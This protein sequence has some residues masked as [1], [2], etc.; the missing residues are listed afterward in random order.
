MCFKLVSQG[1]AKR[2]PLNMER[3]AIIYNL[4]LAKRSVDGVVT[5]SIASTNFIA[6]VSSV[7][8]LA[9]KVPTSC[10]ISPIC[11]ANSDIVLTICC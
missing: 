1:P 2:I 7:S 4:G 3:A 10:R 11:F 8:S 9:D 5:F 6:E